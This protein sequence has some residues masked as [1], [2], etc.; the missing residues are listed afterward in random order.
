[1]SDFSPTN[2]LD[3]TSSITETSDV[4]ITNLVQAGGE[5][6][7]GFFPLD[8]F[9]N[10]DDV[11]IPLAAVCCL[12]VCCMSCTLICIIHNKSMCD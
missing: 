3:A 6:T 2:L 7:A 1:M 10:V 12:T 4:F 11:L 5:Q 9:F 8:L